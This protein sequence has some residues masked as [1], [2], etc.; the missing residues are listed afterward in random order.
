[1]NTVSLQLTVNAA[2]ELLT[3]TAIPKETRDEI[4]NCIIQAWSVANGVV[5]SNSRYRNLTLKIVP[6]GVKIR[7]I[8]AIR[9]NIG[10]DLR[11]SKDFVESVLGKQKD[12]VGEYFG[13]AAATLT[14]LTEDINR[15]SDEL[16]AM[17]CEVV[18]DAYGCP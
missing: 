1:M 11:E 16:R 4:K 8:A 15:L 6:P 7:C 3:N 14:G 9:N 17:G 5:E 13:G 18:T 12:Y 2:L 10:W